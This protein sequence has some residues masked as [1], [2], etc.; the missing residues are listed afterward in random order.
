LSLKIK[1]IVLLTQQYQKMLYQK[2]LNQKFLQLAGSSTAVGG[3]GGGELEAKFL[4][5]TRKR[6]YSTTK[7]SNAELIRRTGVK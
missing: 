3:G 1:L 7:Y 6:R 2:L 4:Q 5:T